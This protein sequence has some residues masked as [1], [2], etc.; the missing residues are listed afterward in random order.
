MK[1]TY[2]LSISGLKRELPLIPISE[3]TSIASFVLLGDAELTHVAAKNMI[4]F[5]PKEFDFI[6]TMESKGIPLAQELS[7]QSGRKE[8]IV[9]RKSIK[10]YMERP[11]TTQVDSITTSGM[12]QLVLNG[13]DVDKISGKKVVVVDDVISTGGSLKAAIDLLE[14]ANV[15]VVGQLAILAEGEASQRKDIK[16]L[17]YLPLF[18]CVS[19]EEK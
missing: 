13:N 9:L 11:I 12:Q 14:K 15:E 17:G 7:V 6:V 1:K 19:G 2:T 18:D 16:Y 5:L 8:Y 10:S 3:D 4:K